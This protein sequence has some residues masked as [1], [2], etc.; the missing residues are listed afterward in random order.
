MPMSNAVHMMKSV[1]ATPTNI[2]INENT[3]TNSNTNIIEL[4]GKILY[5]YSDNINAAFTKKETYPGATVTLMLIIELPG[6]IKDIRSLVEA[7]TSEL[8]ES[9]PES[10]KKALEAQEQA[11]REAEG[12]AVQPEEMLTTPELNVYSRVFPHPFVNSKGYRIGN[13][14]VIVDTSKLPFNSIDEANHFLYNLFEYVNYEGTPKTSKE[15]ER[16]ITDFF[17]YKET[18]LPAFT[19]IRYPD[20]E[21]QKFKKMQKELLD[22]ENAKMRAN[23]R[24]LRNE[25]AGV[26]YGTKEY[27]ENKKL[28]EE[29]TEEIE[30]K[31]IDASGKPKP[32]EE[33]QKLLAAY[34]EAIEDEDDKLSGNVPIFEPEK[35]KEDGTKFP[36]TAKPVNKAAMKGGK[37]KSTNG[38]IKN[39]K[40]RKGKKNNKTKRS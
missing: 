38:S 26:G 22:K 39:R 14:H 4:T 36:M 23:L 2:N 24:R 6:F 40:W 34:A 17:K 32:K 29:L 25:L 8:K 15:M 19:P 27:E 10:K 1:D 28:R 11:K 7:I 5:L 20:E 21:E 31:F 30:K 35:W 16:A 13:W 37:R 3:S 9:L 33:N 12:S 18:K